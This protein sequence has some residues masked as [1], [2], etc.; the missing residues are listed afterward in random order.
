M[1]YSI[2][3]SYVPPEE[4]LM[5]DLLAQSNPEIS[6][7]LGNGELTCKKQWQSSLLGGERTFWMW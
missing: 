6:F 2:D 5:K 3:S 7:L 4:R 1:P